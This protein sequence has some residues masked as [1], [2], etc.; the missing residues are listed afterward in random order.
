MSGFLGQLFQPDPFPSFF[1]ILLGLAV[2]VLLG[3]LPVLGALYVIYFLLTLPLR[4]NERARMFLDLL[5]LGLQS[6]RTPEGAVADVA[7]SRD[8]SLGPRFHLVP[9][10]LQGGL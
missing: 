6:G 7:A 8:Q 3:L 2:Y 4:R 9:A 1:S 10:Y 5:E